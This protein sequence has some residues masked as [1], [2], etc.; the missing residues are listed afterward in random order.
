[1][2]ILSCVYWIIY[3]VLVY[4]VLCSDEPELNGYKGGDNDVIVARAPC[5]WKD[6]LW[7][8]LAHQKQI[9]HEMK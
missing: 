9:Y 7:V 5:P 2:N 1:M 8:F 3:G 6:K 4:S